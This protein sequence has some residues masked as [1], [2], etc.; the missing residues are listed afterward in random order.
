MIFKGQKV[1][2]IKELQDIKCIIII[3]IEKKVF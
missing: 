1:K 3:Y 2:N